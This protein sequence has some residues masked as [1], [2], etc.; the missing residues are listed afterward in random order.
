M[1]P[2]MIASAFPLPAQSRSVHPMQTSQAETHQMSH[3]SP[4]RHSFVWGFC[5]GENIICLVLVLVPRSPLPPI[6]TTGPFP[7]IFTLRFLP[8][9]MMSDHPYPSGKRKYLLAQLRCQDELICSLLKQVCLLYLNGNVC[10]I[11]TL[12]FFFVP[13]STIYSGQFSSVENR[14][15]TR[16]VENLRQNTIT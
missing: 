10:V 15:S 5:T 4:Q 2:L 16:F 11:S 6:A 9:I 13:S 7:H 14:N 1:V 12:S 3:H 8:V